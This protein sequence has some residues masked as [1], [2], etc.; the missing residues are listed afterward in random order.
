M[1]KCWMT[2]QCSHRDRTS[3]SLRQF[4]FSRSAFTPFT[5]CISDHIIKHHN[6]Q[7]CKVFS[8]KCVKLIKI[9]KLS[10]PTE[11]IKF[12]NLRQLSEWKFVNISAFCTVRKARCG[13]MSKAKI[14]S[15]KFRISTDKLLSLF[16]AFS[17]SAVFKKKQS[18]Y[19]FHFCGFAV[20]LHS[21]NYESHSY[22][23]HFSD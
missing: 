4:H 17:L 8:S 21:Y 6:F 22:I 2:S 13:K 19:E 7:D 16:L 20:R 10:Q 23:Q 9:F 5:Y 1:K 12:L 18:F 14:T 3:T 15:F 11:L